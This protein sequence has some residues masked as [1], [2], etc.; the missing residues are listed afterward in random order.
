MTSPEFPKEMYRDVGERISA[1][2]SVLE[3]VPAGPLRAVALHEGLEQAIRE[4][5]NEILAMGQEP[6][7]I[8]CKKG[9]ERSF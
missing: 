2:R 5:T 9:T 6:P 4:E 1:Y 3:S 8:T 7:K